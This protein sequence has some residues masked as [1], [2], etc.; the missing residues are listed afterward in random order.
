MTPRIIERHLAAVL[1]NEPKPWPE[2][3]AAESAQA[4]VVEEILYHGIAGLLIDRAA[5]LQG[6][7]GQVIAA[8]RQQAI[9]QA[10]WELQHQRVLAEL[11]SA[12]GREGIVPLFLKGTAIAYDL[13]ET[14][15][16]RSRG[17]SDLLVAATDVSRARTVLEALGYR[18]GQAGGSD[19]MA[20]QEAWTLTCDDGTR[21]PIDLH[22]QVMNAPALQDALPF[23]ECSAD[24][25]ALPRL[26]SSARGLDRARALIHTCMHRSMHVTAPYFVDG[27]TYY[28]ADRLIWIHDVHLLASALSPEDWRRFCALCRKYGAAAVCLDGLRAAQ[29]SLATDIPAA[30]C[31]ELGRAPRNEKASRYLLHS[32]QLGRAWQD[33]VAIHGAGRKLAYLRS[34]ILP[35]AA[36]VRAKYGDS[37]GTPVAR[38]YLR[39]LSELLRPRPQRDAER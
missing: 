25:L 15:A 7:P 20:L 35:S 16:N 32:R 13:Y 22:S 34:R 8:V 31:A 2:S 24:S 39:R 9:A 33:L 1:R 18:P 14:P 11:I 19:P 37:A 5:G 38:L 3:W 27:Q 28:G 36:F 4:A 29:R 21:H 10:M 26:S 23:A 12:L 17:D 30:V 6:W